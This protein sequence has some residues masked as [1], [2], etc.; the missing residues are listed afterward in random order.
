MKK[1]LIDILVCPVCKGRLELKVDS[2]KDE[3]IISG[4]FRCGKCEATY[5]VKDGIPYLLPPGGKE[6]K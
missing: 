4:L 5:P 3:E 6:A 1:T 2:A